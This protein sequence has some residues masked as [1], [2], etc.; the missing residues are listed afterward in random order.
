M[1]V[2]LKFNLLLMM[3]CWMTILQASM[4]EYDIFRSEIEKNIER[5]EMSYKE[6]VVIINNQQVLD[7]IQNLPKERMQS[8]FSAVMNFMNGAQEKKIEMT[9]SAWYHLN[10]DPKYVKEIA[11][12]A[13]F[14]ECKKLFHSIISYDIFCAQINKNIELIEMRYK[15]FLNSG[16]NRINDQEVLSQIRSL[17]KQTIGMQS[18]IFAVKHFI[19]GAEAK[20]TELTE[21]SWNYLDKDPIYVKE[22][23]VIAAFLEYKQVAK[24]KEK[25]SYLLRRAKEL[26]VNSTVYSLHSSLDILLQ[27][28]RKSTNATNKQ[29]IKDQIIDIRDKIMKALAQDDFNDTHLKKTQNTKTTIIQRLKIENIIVDTSERKKMDDHQKFTYYITQK[30]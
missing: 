10:K 8:T 16:I 25:S 11:V 23:V 1:M 17:P 12:M 18:T 2:Y 14:L 21:N 3:C 27:D 15:G 4:L 20:K 26:E 29:K 30:K 13:A 28:F 6:K 9:D 19:K 7:Q 5:I 24:P 22:I